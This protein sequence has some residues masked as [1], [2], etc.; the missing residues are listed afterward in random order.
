MTTH[1]PDRKRREERIAERV[2]SKLGHTSVEGAQPM[3]ASRKL[4]LMVLGAALILASVLLLVAGLQIGTVWTLVGGLMIAFAIFLVVGLPVLGPMS[5]RL[6][7]ENMARREARR[8]VLF[9]E[10][11]ERRQARAARHARHEPSMSPS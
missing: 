1:N 10:R 3:P 5:M 8:E 4:S 6:R 11:R 7:E 2:A 9:E